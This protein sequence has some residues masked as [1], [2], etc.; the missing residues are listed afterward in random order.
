MNHG[1]A[2]YSYTP[3]PPEEGIEDYDEYF[4]PPVKTHKHHHEHVMQQERHCASGCP[5]RSVSAP[6]PVPVS[7]T[8]DKSLDSLDFKQLLLFAGVGILFVV[9]VDAIVRLASSHDISSTK[10]GAITID[11]KS[12]IPI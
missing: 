1:R 9:A 11:G 5:C 6:A 10:A 8:S 7:S 3:Q 2:R 4:V 12:Y